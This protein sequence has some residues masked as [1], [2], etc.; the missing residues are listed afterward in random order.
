MNNFLINNLLYNSFN[1]ILGVVMKILSYL[2][3]GALLFTGCSYKNGA[4]NVDSYK[5][6]YSG[7]LAKH[8]KAIDLVMVKDIRKDKKNIGYFVNDKDKS[9][10]FHSN[11]DFAKRYEDGLKKALY[12]AGYKVSSK[13]TPMK[14]QVFIQ[15]IE[16][17][18]NDKSFDENLKG[19]IQLSVVLT[20][21]RRTIKQSF[22]QEK[23][24]WM[25]PSYDSKDLEPFLYELFS[26]SIND[27]VGRL[28]NY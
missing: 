16:L 28:T 3:V 25:Q 1:Y 14:M 9:I 22:K 17:V 2:V 6:N 20:N 12:A 5:T 11:T 21:G 4:I 18:K 15:K 19:K 7:P 27:V 24:K 10:K 13:D 8:T 23:S 26:D